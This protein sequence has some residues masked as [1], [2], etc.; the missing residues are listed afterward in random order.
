MIF[1]FS[2]RLISRVE[3]SQ[4]SSF[5]EAQSVEMQSSLQLRQHNSSFQ[6]ILS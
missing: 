5:N 6:E 2:Q 1:Q 4:D 3:S